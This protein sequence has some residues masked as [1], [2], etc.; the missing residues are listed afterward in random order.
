M[1]NNVNPLLGNIQEDVMAFLNEIQLKYPDAIS[2]ASGRPD[3]SYF[4]I[5]DFPENFN[6]YVEALVQSTNSDRDKVL[7]GLGQYNRAKGIA[8]DLLSLYFLKDEKINVLPEDI[9]ITVGTQEAL[10]LSVMTLCDRKNDVILV[11]DPSYIGITHFSL[12][13]GHQI[14]AIAM[15]EDGVSMEGIEEKVVDL[16]QDGKKVR[17]V[18][19]IPDFQNPTG[20]YMSLKKR[21]RLLELADKYDFFILED[22]AYSDFRYHEEEFLPIKALD[23]NKRVVYIRSFSKTLYPSLRIAAMIADSAVA[24]PHGE[25]SLSDLIARTKGYLTV[26]TPS[27]NQAILGGILIKNDCSLYSANQSKVKSMKE[28][29]DLLLFYLNRSLRDQEGWG[30][31]ITWNV[32]QGGFFMTIRVPFEV[33]R[34]EVIGCAEKYKV[35]FTPMAFFYL[36]DGGNNEIRIA[37]S[38]LSAGQLRDAIGRLISYFK[39]KIYN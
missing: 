21:R 10:A 37:F 15:E 39:S 22:N 7:K 32:P 5:K 11:E 19:V 4:E 24:I 25:A 29:R 12:I 20:A 36:K 35:I 30:E 38:N 27:I 18:Y 17:I 2:L 1:A 9:I 26:N 14:E 34:K 8:N 6:R 23:E 13:S 33:D 31:D 3:E 16:A 28:K